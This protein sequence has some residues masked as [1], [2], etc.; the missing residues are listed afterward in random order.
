SARRGDGVNILEGAAGAQQRFRN[1]AVE[2]L[3]MGA[4]RN[5]RHDAA[6]SAMLFELAQNDLAKNLAPALLI[7]HDDRSGG[8]VAARFDAE[9]GQMGRHEAL[10]LIAIGRKPGYETSR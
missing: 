5:F 10:G 1:Q 9:D 4:R 7:A 8:F 6:I 3:D 2:R